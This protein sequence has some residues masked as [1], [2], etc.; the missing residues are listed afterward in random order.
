MNR[1]PTCGTSY[2]DDARFCTRDGTRLLGQTPQASPV[3]PPA[4]PPDQANTPRQTIFPARHDKKAPVTHANLVG[5]TLQGH[6]EIVRKVGEGGMSFVYLA[7][8]IATRER[9][10]IKVLSA[11]LSHDR[12]AMARLRR[13]ASFGMRLAHPNICHI[14]RLGETEDGLIYV[15]MPFVD[16]EIL[17]DRTN[18]LG[19]LPVREV[20]R[21]LK[22]MATGLHVAH[23]LKIVH[24]DL[25][26][27]NVMVC[28][29]PDG[30]EYAVVLD[31][32]LA[33]ERKAGLELQK[34]TATG[35]VLG[36]PEF[37]SPEQL[38]GKPL[39][40]RTDIYSLGLMVFEMLTG[41]LPFTGRTQQ[42]TMIARLRSEPTPLRRV[43]PDLGFS[44]ALEK[45]LDKAMERNADDRYSTAP[46][47][48]DA[49]AVAAG[50]RPTPSSSEGGLLGKLFGR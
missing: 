33:K 5:K 1:C 12:N 13:E 43:R 29:R 30:S 11:S 39:D 19:Q 45:V 40:A 49:F 6:Y 34:L 3:V 15:V 14:I 38:R 20:S 37:M 28:R 17:S 2:P 16:G 31:F 26:P 27:E 24:R 42:E 8:D 22:D 32:G 44:E 48:A 35:I 36:T 50:E 7:N 47:F 21:L 41:S 4:A 25:K 9:Y 46:E 10:A 18:R 23:E